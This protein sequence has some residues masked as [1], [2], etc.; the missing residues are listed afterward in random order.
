MVERGIQLKTRGELQAMRASGRVLAAAIVAG[1]AAVA[2]GRQHAGHQ[3][4]GRRRHR[5]RRRDQQLPAL[6][7][8]RRRPRFP[9]DHLRVGERRG[10]ARHP[11][12][13]PDPARGRPAVHRR[14]LHPGR[15]AFRLRGLGARRRAAVD[16][17]GR[18]DRRL[19]PGD[20]GRDRR[21][22]RRRPARRRLLRDRELGRASPVTSD[23]R[24]YGSVEGYGGHGIGTAMH[25][26]PFVPEP[27]QARQGSA[28]GG[29]AP[30]W[31]SSR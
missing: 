19:R 11:A 24:R 28:A 23:G 22:P 21:G 29:R 18:P 14:R 27:G 9:G 5:R 25:M 2:P 4:R 10:R 15:L 8:P 16:G 6:R 17:G 31:R 1:R 26:A 20:V 13:R 12:R 30:R 3:R 7:R